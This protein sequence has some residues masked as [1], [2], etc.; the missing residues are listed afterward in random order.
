MLQ[1]NSFEEKGEYQR[2]KY[3]Y[4][5]VNR[6]ASGKDH[7]NTEYQT[8]SAVRIA[9][10]DS[11]LAYES[12]NS[13]VRW[14][15]LRFDSL[16][17][18][19]NPVWQI[20]ELERVI[21][22][23]QALVYP[24]LKV[25]QLWNEN[26]GITKQVRILQS[27][28]KREAFISKF[29][30]EKQK[31]SNGNELEGYFG[32][33]SLVSEKHPNAELDQEIEMLE[34][35]LS[36]EI[37]AYELLLSA[38][39]SLVANNQLEEAKKQYQTAL[40]VNSECYKCIS[41]LEMMAALAEMEPWTDVIYAQKLQE[42]R[43]ATSIGELLVAKRI[44]QHILKNEPMDKSATEE[45]SR[46]DEQLSRQQTQRQLSFGVKL[47]EERADMHFDKSEYALALKLYIEL[48]EKYASYVS[49]IKMI[50][51]RILICTDKTQK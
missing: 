7:F 42:A 47:Q 37:A 1:G 25:D 14:H 41:Q 28:A 43:S 30:S 24:K 23:N 51:E 16:V 49:D 29:K 46:V 15:M 6:L 38:G 32:L 10:Q 4:G 31:V 13:Q 8:L 45:L 26:P 3:Y 5:L 20:V 2:A 9:V 50:E 36:S 34:K 48:K 35:K 11:L 22:I 17:V 40:T 39:D 44:Y 21:E 33:K 27:K 19:C 12:N 18:C